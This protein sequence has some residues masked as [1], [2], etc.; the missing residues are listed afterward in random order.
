MSAEQDPTG[1][2]TRAIHE[3]YLDMQRA[4]KEYR[5]A[6]DRG[7]QQARD[8]AH[9]EVQEAVLTLYEM[10]RPH[11]KHNSAV[12]EYWDGQ[13][14]SYPPEDAP[15]ETPDPD[16]GRGVLA[17]QV[18][19]Q[20]YEL[21]GTDPDELTTLR[22]WHDALGVADTVRL[23]GVSANGEQVMVRYQTYEMGLRRL[24]D[25]QTEFDTVQ[26]DLGGFMG[27]RS[28]QKTVRQRVP[29]EKLRRAARELSNVAEELGA[30]SEFD[31]STPRTKITDELIEEV[32]EWREQNI[33]S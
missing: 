10:L 9:G 2:P 14:P 20:T 6:T 24:D 8:R 26:S 21:N 1:I 11:I 28:S 19:P 33:E 32:D 18:H 7:S 27:G 30:L 12:N 13:P 16:D 23:T 3:A 15:R 31:A 29:I 4:L 25:W 22:D 17:S 5:R